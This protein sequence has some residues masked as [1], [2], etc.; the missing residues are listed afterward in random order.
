MMKLWLAL[1]VL[2]A[3]ATLARPAAA[4][5]HSG[6]QATITAVCNDGTN[7]TGASKQG[8]CSGHKGVKTW[9]GPPAGSAASQANT[10]GNKPAT[11]GATNV[12]PDTNVPA[13]TPSP[14]P[15]EK[16]SGA[17]QPGQVWVNTA[18]NVYHCPG[19]R[20]FGKTKQGKFMSEADAKKAGIKPDHG[21]SCPK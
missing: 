3:S 8:A 9:S 21:N 19:D 15:K 1:P 12:K 2:F 4:Q 13:K 14:S 11:S 16:A 20:F 17:G 5:T 6:T 18:T 10:P 7:W